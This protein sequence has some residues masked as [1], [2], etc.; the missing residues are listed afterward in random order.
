MIRPTFMEDLETFDAERKR[1]ATPA[2]I[3]AFQNKWFPK[4][5]WPECQKPDEWA[6]VS[7]HARRNR[8]LA[9]AATGRDWAPKMIS[10]ALEPGAR[11]E[12]SKTLAL[13]HEVLFPQSNEGPRKLGS[14]LWHLSCDYCLISTWT[15]GDIN[16][17]ICRRELVYTWLGN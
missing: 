1:V 4:E 6:E 7:S 13:F 8:D 5:G 3:K 2:D 11:Y 10:Y 12:Y 14:S 16:C 17:P 9:E 15:E